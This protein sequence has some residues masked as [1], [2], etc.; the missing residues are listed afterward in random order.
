MASSLHYYFGLV[1]GTKNLR[2]VYL[3][4]P[5][6]VFRIVNVELMMPVLLMK[7]G[8]G[9]AKHACIHECLLH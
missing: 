9:A 3:S 5:R 7:Q 2:K 6:I 8:G 1:E 4:A